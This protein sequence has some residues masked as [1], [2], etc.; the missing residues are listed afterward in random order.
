MKSDGGGTC[1]FDS[2]GRFWFTLPGSDKSICIPFLSR[3]AMDRFKCYRCREP[4][5]EDSTVLMRPMFPMADIPE[6][7]RY[8]EYAVVCL[9][10]YDSWDSTDTQQDNHA[11]GPVYMNRLGII[12]SPIHKASFDNV[13]SVMNDYLIMHIRALLED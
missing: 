3:Q 7:C 6:E 5:E 13:E 2:N 12:N 1:L 8:F 9:A 4:C 10:C 11:L